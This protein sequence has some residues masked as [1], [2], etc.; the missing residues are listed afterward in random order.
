MATGFPFGILPVISMDA[1]VVGFCLLLLFAESESC[2]L[3]PK[4]ASDSEFYLPQTYAP[5]WDYKCAPQH[6]TLPGI[7]FYLVCTLSPAA[8]ASGYF[9]RF[10]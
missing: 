8:L 10:H 1:K 7:V 9:I 3:W 2:Y 5:Y 4:L 6:T